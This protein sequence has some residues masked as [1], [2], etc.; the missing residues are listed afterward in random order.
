MSKKI[1]LLTLTLIFPVLIYMFLQGFGDNKFAI[2]KYYQNGIDTT[3]VSCGELSQPFAWKAQSL[4]SNS[5]EEKDIVIYDAFGL[6]TEGSV[7]ARNNLLSFLNKYKDELNVH[8]ISVNPDSL[9]FKA[10]TGFSNVNPVYVDEG[11]QR[12]F[13]YCNLVINNLDSSL[14]VLVDKERNIRGY[15][16]PEKIKEIDRLN[17]EVLI[18]LE[19]GDE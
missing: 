16:S 6:T 4:N 18:L 8:M 7:D 14:L 3:L 11:S 15:F 12:A 1:V 17:T 19:E 2:P 10:L 13:A 9:K 5:S